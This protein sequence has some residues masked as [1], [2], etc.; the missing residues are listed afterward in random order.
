MAPSYM[1]C[2]IDYKKAIEEHKKSRNDITMI[3]KNVNNADKY[4]IGCNVLNIN[5][6]RKLLSVGENLGR[7]SKSNID[8]EMY[9]MST[10]L[11]IDIVLESIRSGMYRK[12]KQFIKSNL[13]K[14]SVGCFE[15]KGYLA[16]VNSLNSYYSSNMDLLKKRVNNELFYE[17]KPIF[18]KTKDEAPTQYGRESNVTNSIIANGCYIGGEV[19]NSIIGRRVYIEEGAK[20]EN[21][22]ILQ[23]SIIGKEAILKNVIADKRSKVKEEEIYKGSN[24]CPVVIEKSKNF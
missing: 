7:E 20:I 5:E 4:F 2:N 21:C 8:M 13:D 9:I 23:N 1:I 17:G 18:T 15:F 12:I 19:K 6:S 14:I 16:C 11:F 24:S 3:Y 22:I 10:E